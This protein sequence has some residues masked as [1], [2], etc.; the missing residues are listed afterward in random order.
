MW[1]IPTELVS[2]FVLL[3]FMWFF[4]YWIFGGIFFAIVSLLRLGRVRKARFSCLFSLA[5]VVCAVGAS[6]T[7]VVWGRA[8]IESC[9]TAFDEEASSFLSAMSC[10]FANITSS[11]LIWSAVLIFLGLIIMTISKSKEHTW[12]DKISN[13]IQEISEGEEEEEE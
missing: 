9:G 11:F 8:T 3:S 5:S 7:G 2:V 6:Y 10:G 4:V 12:F 13:R 1:N